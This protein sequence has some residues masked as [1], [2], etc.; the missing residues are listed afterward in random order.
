MLGTVPGTWDPLVNTTAP[1]P[2]HC[3]VYILV[4]EERQQT[5][6]CNG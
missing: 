1:N 4:K 2:S 6:N 5:K 3:E